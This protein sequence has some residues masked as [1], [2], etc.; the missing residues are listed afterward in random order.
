LTDLCSSSRLITGCGVCGSNSVEIVPAADLVHE[1]DITG[2]RWEFTAMQ[3]IPSGTTGTSFFILL[4]T[5]ND[6]G[7]KDWS[8]QTQFNLGTGA[9]TTQYDSSASAVIVYDQW[10]EFKCVIDLDDNTVDEYYNG[11]FFS[12]HQWDGDLHKTLQAIDLFGN[13]ASSVYYDDIVIA[14]PLGAYNPQPADD[15]IHAD[16]WVN[17]KWGPGGG[18]VSHDVYMGDDFGRVV[19]ATRDSDVFRINQT[20]TF[21]LAGFPGFAYPDGLVPGTT[22]YWRVDEVNDADPNS[23]WRGDVWSFSIPPKTAYNPDPADGAEF[24]NPD[25]VLQWTG[26][27]GAKFHTI[28]FGDNF[29][30][31]N[32]AAG[33]VMSG[34]ATYRPPSPFGVEKVIYW[35]VDEFD[36]ATTHKGDIWSFKTLPY[37]TIT[38]P[39][40][41]GWWK[42]DE[43]SG[44]MALDGSGYGNHGTLIR[45]PQ[46]VTGHDGD[47]LEFDGAGTYVDCGNDTTFDITDEITL[48]AWV[49][50]S[51]LTSFPRAISKQSC[52]SPHRASCPCHQSSH[53][54]RTISPHP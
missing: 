24:V 25:T 42:L 54:S 34:S 43:G 52:S 5:Y 32:S 45:D 51:Q 1:F 16:T 6:G 8:V 41:L 13:N 47:A 14:A 12:T 26:G 18:A 48:E 49:N 22:Y 33:G 37:I 3:Y 53:L 19:E 38:D 23:P 27:Y 9:I 15:A 44:V 40:L 29:E 4:N 50:Y 28:Y 39:N 10:V 17:L 30:E 20:D 7:S 21:Y 11:V 46:W 2:G 31:V 36:G 35:R